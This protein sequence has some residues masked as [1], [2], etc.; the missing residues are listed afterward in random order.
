MNERI[1]NQGKRSLNRR[2]NFEETMDSRCAKNGW[3]SRRC[4]IGSRRAA[5]D[6]G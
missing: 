3:M 2:P 5:A 4:A 1:R 6:A